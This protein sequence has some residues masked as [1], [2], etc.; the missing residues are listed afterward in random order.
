MQIKVAYIATLEEYYHADTAFRQALSK[1]SVDLYVQI[2]LWLIAIAFM[3]IGQFVLGGTMAVI[4]F[5]LQQGYAKRWI[6]RRNFY[7]MVNSGE[8]ETLT[9]SEENILY[10]CGMISEMITWED[11]A[12]YLETDELF[13]VFYDASDHYMI[14]PKRAMKNEEEIDQ[15]RQLCVRQLADYEVTNV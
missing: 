4:A 9:F 8:Q 6:V 13:M 15:L 11:Y 10:E 3:A 12:A 5:I 7:K 14:I 1:N 2:A